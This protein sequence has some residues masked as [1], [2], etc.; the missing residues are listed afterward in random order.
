[1]KNDRMARNYIE[2]AAKKLKQVER[3]VQDGWWPIAVRQS[4]ECVEQ[5]LKAALRFVGIEPPKWHDVREILLE[6]KE[7]FP[8]WFAQEVEAL[9]NI[10]KKLSE[11]RELSFYGDEEAGKTPDEL[12][13]EADA[14][15]AFEGAKKT[16]ELCHRIIFGGL[17]NRDEP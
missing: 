3:A 12:F 1:M 7:R 9:S 11:V 6:N 16:Y 13:G 8:A 10:S 14:R 5:S 2:Q 4:Q 17:L 15:Q